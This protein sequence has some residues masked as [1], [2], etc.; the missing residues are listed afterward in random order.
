MNERQLLAMKTII[1]EY[2]KVYEDEVEKDRLVHNVVTSLSFPEYLQLKYFLN[3][4]ISQG[5]D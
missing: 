4:R 3:D 2:P 5:L 1:C